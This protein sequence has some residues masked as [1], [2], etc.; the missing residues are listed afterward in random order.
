MARAVGQLGK[1]ALTETNFGAV[2]TYWETVIL[3]ATDLEELAGQVRHCRIRDCK[4][5]EGKL[6]TCRVVLAIDAKYPDT[7]K[8]VEAA[9]LQQKAIKK[10]GPAPRGPLE[11][12]AAKLLDSLK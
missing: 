12:E 3:G 8:V 6:K 2:K 7:E 4:V 5:K 9:L 10:V 1:E 11:P